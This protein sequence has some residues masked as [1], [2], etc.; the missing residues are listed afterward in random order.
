MGPVQFEVTLRM[1]TLSKPTQPLMAVFMLCVG[2]F[3][4]YKKATEYPVSQSVEDH[5]LYPLLL[6][7][8]SNKA[9]CHFH[10]AV[11]SD[12]IVT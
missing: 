10:G 6:R 2:M 7:H 3:I 9:R 5:A 11:F 1:K 8:S 12:L 4:K